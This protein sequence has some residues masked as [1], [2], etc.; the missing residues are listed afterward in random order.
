MIYND[1]IIMGAQYYEIIFIN[2]LLLYTTALETISLLLYIY[3]FNFFSRIFFASGLLNEFFK[4]KIIYSIPTNLFIIL[5]MNI[6]TTKSNNSCEYK[7]KISISNLHE[8]LVKYIGTFI[9]ARTLSKG[10]FIKLIIYTISITIFIGLTPI[11]CKIYYS[12]VRTRMINI[13]LSL[14]F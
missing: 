11:V 14:S 1:E 3:L 7:N 5:L 13:P 6:K 9:F 10:I 8:N 12:F 2:W 4:L